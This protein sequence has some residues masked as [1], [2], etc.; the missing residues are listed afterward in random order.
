MGK[1]PQTVY[2]WVAG[3]KKP[4]KETIQKLNELL[5]SNLK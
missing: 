1:H 4:G 2:K 5:G 3:D